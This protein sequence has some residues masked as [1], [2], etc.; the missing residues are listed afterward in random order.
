MKRVTMLSKHAQVSIPSS[1]LKND[2]SSILC[3]SAAFLCRS[4]CRPADLPI[5]RLQVAQQCSRRG[6]AEAARDEAQL[7][8]KQALA[9]AAAANDRAV[10]AEE[11]SAAAVKDCR[12]LE[13]RA[14]MAEKLV[15]S[16]IFSETHCWPR[17]LRAR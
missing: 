2:Q 12:R 13:A 1:A 10:A 3:T 17:A 7:R 6:E 8:S 15:R 5:M 9:D 16:Q 11:S 14:A 4:L